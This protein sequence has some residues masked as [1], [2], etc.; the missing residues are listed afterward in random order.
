[1][2]GKLLLS[3]K[4]GA[5]SGAI[6][7][8]FGFM[9]MLG[10]FAPFPPASAIESF[11]S[12]VPASIQEPAV[13]NFGAFAKDLGL[14]VAVIISVIVY[15]L[16][17]ILF[18]KIFRHRLARIRVLSSFEKFLAYSLV[19][20]VFFAVMVL[21]ATGEGPFGIFSFNAPKDAILVYPFA[22]LL[23]QL[24]FG[25]ALSWQYKGASSFT[26]VIGNAQTEISQS[27]P[28]LRCSVFGETALKE[29][30]H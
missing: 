27:S 26:N 12:I 15:G 13:Q 23:G 14:L 25:V 18:E 6:A 22:L 16:F 21:F 5:L 9:M 11:V 24:I 1:M 29:D 20:Y 8:V 4:N 10:G 2:S 30:F 17:G 7:L 19:P 28:R 3:F